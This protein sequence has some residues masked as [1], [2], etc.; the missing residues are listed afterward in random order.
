MLVPNVMAE[1]LGLSSEY[2]VYAAGFAIYLAV[3]FIQK[4]KV[5]T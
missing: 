5:R 3:Y 2:L 1:K 4:N